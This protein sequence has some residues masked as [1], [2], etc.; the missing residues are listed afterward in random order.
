MRGTLYV[1]ATPIG[2]LEDITQRALRVL[3]EVDLI[4]AEDT[5]R[6]RVLLEHYQIEN[7]L[8]SLYEH[9][10]A[11][12]A[13]ALIRQLEEGANIA[14]V[15]EAGTPLISDPGYRL[16]QLAIVREITIVP[17]PG[18]SALIA[19]LVVSGLPV[20]AFIFE[21]FLPKRPGKRRRRLEALKHEERTLIVYESPRRVSALLEEMLA[22][23]GDRH[24]AVARELTKKFEEVLRG[25]I[26][27]VHAHLAEHPPLGE[28][29]LV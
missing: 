6:T 23:W 5:R 10:E 1:V 13:A 15:S 20:D 28:V 9:N 27:Q 2:N 21:G 29:T 19:A 12:K 14:L 11:A 17:I 26:T 18:P 8:T 4:A 3:R 16:I 25:T 24:V 7:A 22:A